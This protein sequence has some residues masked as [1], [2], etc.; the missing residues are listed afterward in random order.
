M[1]EKEYI[2]RGEVLKALRDWFGCSVE[3]NENCPVT[4]CG[5]GRIIMAAPA[6]NDRVKEMTEA[7][8]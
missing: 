3:C 2:E 1:A 6:A 8:L 4:E 7:T 5:E